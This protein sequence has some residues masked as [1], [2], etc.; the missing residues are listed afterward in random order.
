MREGGIEKGKR[1]SV[2]RQKGSMWKI[3]FTFSKPH[4]FNNEM[5]A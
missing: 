4:N 2:R 1:G 3:V 5:M